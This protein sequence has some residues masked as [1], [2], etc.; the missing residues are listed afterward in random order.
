MSAEERA[1]AIAKNIEGKAQ[2]ALG[3]LTGDSQA[4]VEGRA[5]QAHSE[6]IHAKENFKDKAK[7]V[8]DEIF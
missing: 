1:K 3:K 6:A 8:I 7:R 5:K 2:E 4:Q